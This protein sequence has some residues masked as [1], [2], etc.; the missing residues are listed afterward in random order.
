LGPDEEAVDEEAN[1]Y[2]LALWIACV[3][4][5]RRRQQAAPSETCTPLPSVV[6]IGTARLQPIAIADSAA[7]SSSPCFGLTL[8][9]TMLSLV[10]LPGVEQVSAGKAVGSLE[11]PCRGEEMNGQSSV[12]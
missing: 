7:R 2:G 12:P 11:G 1:E 6:E 10:A 8:H 9:T 4:M 5:L 3:T